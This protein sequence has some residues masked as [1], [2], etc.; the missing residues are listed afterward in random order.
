M[1]DQIAIQQQPPPRRRR[2]PGKTTTSVPY[3]S[4]TSGTKAREETSKV[5]ERLSCEKIGFMDELK[6][7]AV[8]LQFTHRGRTVQLRASAK[9]WA[10][11]FLMKSSN[12]SPSGP[13]AGLRCLR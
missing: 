7:H 9:G 3:A 5:L 12:E 4:A 6:E 8:L 11:M 1:T 10:Q 2:R 13:S